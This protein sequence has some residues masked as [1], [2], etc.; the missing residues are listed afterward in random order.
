MPLCSCPVIFMLAHTHLAR[1]A[2]YSSFFALTKEHGG[3]STQPPHMRHM[4]RSAP[5]WL[6]DRLRRAE[7]GRHCAQLQASSPRQWRRTS[8]AAPADRPYTSPRRPADRPSRA[9]TVGAAQGPLLAARRPGA[10]A[11]VLGRPR[12]P[13]AVG[14]RVASRAPP[15]AVP[16]A[17]PALCV[18]PALAAA[19]A[20]AAAACP[21]RRRV[22]TG[23]QL[24]PALRYSR[25]RMSRRR[26]NS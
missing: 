1:K 26:P 15:L 8:R 13:P 20:H 21:A 19:A 5:L 12:G 22:R 17:T 18:H 14:R 16:P 6:G 7:H 2:C 23:V 9:L 10:A 24:L 4:W 3:A 25:Q 11:A